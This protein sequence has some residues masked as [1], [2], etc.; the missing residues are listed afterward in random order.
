[1]TI[2]LRLSDV[3]PPAP[4]PKRTIYR[5]IANLPDPVKLGLTIRYFNHDDVGLYFQIT[6]SGTGYTFG[7]VNLGLLASGKNA[8][9]NLDEFASRAKP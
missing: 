7:T 2:E 9:I 1:M 5:D 4:E 8:Y 3:D 6:G